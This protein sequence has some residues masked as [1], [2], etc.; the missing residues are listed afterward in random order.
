MR[1]NIFI[2]AIAIA[3]ATFIQELR[4][5]E[6][7]GVN[8]NLALITLSISAFLVGDIMVYGFLAF[9]GAIFIKIGPY[10]EVTT[11][12]FLIVAIF[13]WI[14]KNAG[15]WSADVGFLVALFTATTIFYAIVDYRFI[16]DHS[17]LFLGEMIYNLL[18]G[19]ATWMVAPLFSHETR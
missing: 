6:I 9:W 14:A 5:L 3:I 7:W 8:P 11:L 2:F 12:A 13:L 4:L 1:N 16:L 19:A 17:N 10:T 15:P 18:L